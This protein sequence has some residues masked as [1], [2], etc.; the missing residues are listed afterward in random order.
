M[1]GVSD[2]EKI[3]FSINIQVEMAKP[4]QQRNWKTMD[5][6]KFIKTLNQ[7]IESWETSQTTEPDPTGTNI[8]KDIDTNIEKVVDALNKAIKESTPWS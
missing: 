3:E 7:E 6:A 4:K 8:E 2:H 1:Y 5:Q